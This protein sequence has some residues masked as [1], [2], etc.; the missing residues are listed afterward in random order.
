MWVCRPCLLKCQCQMIPVRLYFCFKCS[1][2]SSTSFLETC[3]EYPHCTSRFYQCTSRLPFGLVWKKTQ[4]A[5][6]AVSSPRN[7]SWKRKISDNEVRSVNYTRF[8]TASSFRRVYFCRCSFPVDL[9]TCWGVMERKPA[10]PGINAE[11]PDAW[12]RSAER[13]CRLVVR[14]RKRIKHCGTA[15][16]G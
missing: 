15:T 5:H 13:C 3:W 6:T 14:T 2:Q 10:P 8:R 9:S 7:T 11:Q 4:T 1:L 12:E 16:G